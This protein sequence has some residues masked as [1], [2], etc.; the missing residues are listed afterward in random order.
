MSHEPNIIERLAAADPARQHHGPSASSRAQARERILT[1][2]R[3]ARQ[4]RGRRAGRLRLAAVAVGAVVT[5][6]AVLLIARAG[7]PTPRASAAELLNTSA[8]EVGAPIPPLGVGE[9]LYTQ[10]VGTRRDVVVDENGDQRF[11]TVRFDREMWIGRDGGGQVVAHEFR[12]GSDKPKVTTTPLGN[13]DAPG[14]IGFPFG[15]RSLTLKQVTELPTDPDLLTREV[16]SSVA[17]SNGQGLAYHQLDLVA[18]LLRNAPVPPELTA[19]LYRVLSRLPGLETLG[20]RRDSQGRAGQVIGA[21]DSAAGLRLELLLDPKTG[22]PLADRTV[23]TVAIGGR[24]GFA[25][26]GDV[27]QE[28]TYLGRSAVPSISARP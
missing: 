1:V 13:E 12:A 26:A 16:E 23:A 3:S 20:E 9:Y 22:L 5:V 11:E 21:T 7:D 27:V 19:A 14:P 15:N 28:T 4:S 10:S 2:E 6:A 17:G 18:E 8:S 24:R 25:A